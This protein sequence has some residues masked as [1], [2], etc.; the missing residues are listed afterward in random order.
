MGR[1]GVLHT[2]AKPPPPD[3]LVSTA[4]KAEWHCYIGKSQSHQSDPTVC[5]AISRK[6]Q[7]WG[8]GGSGGGEIVR[9]IL[10]GQIGGGF[11]A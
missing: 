11:C 6:D 7:A 3:L 4:E 5:V 10:V 1:L 9:G 2:A 8:W